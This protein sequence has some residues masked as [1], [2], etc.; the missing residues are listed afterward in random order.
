MKA[1]TALTVVIL[2]VCLAILYYVRRE[3]IGEVVLAPMSIEFDDGFLPLGAHDLG[4]I[5]PDIAT[6]YE[7]GG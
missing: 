7:A 5:P 3:T 2:G 4:F 6:G 1:L